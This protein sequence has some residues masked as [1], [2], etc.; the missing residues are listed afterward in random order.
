M[1]REIANTLLCNF[2]TFPYVFYYKF[3]LILC[4][5]IFYTSSSHFCADKPRTAHGI[6]EK[7]GGMWMWL[8]ISCKWYGWV[9]ALQYTALVSDFSRSQNIASS[10]GI[11]GIAIEKVFVCKYLGTFFSKDLRLRPNSDSLYKKIKSRVYAYSNF[12]PFNPSVDKNILSLYNLWC[13]PF[14]YTILR[15]G[16][17]CVQKERDPCF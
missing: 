15:C 8:T 13:F 11:N 1:P 5:I 9:I 12:E 2:A 14:Y 3:A 17:T 4:I 7:G 10:V 6:Q 16:L